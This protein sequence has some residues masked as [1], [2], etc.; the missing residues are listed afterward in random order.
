MRY[1]DSA[2]GP[3]HLVGHSYG[4]CVALRAAI[5]RPTR[6]ASMALYE[7]VAFYVLKTLGP[8]G[9]IALKEI[10][11]L[12]GEISL[13]VLSGNHQ[14]AAKRFFEFWNG[15]GSWSA[16]RPEPQEDLVRYIP[17]VCL[18]FSASINECTPLVAYRRLNFPILL[19]QG[20]HAPLP[21][22]MIARRLSKT[23]KSASLQTVHGAGHMGPFSHAQ[24]VSEL[25]AAWIMRVE[26]RFS[27][28]EGDAEPAIGRAA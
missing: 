24:V 15:A 3:V 28:D 5:E 27:T 22:Q 4:G 23:M 20:E 12:A 16:L 13:F 11:A 17:K 25:M 21:T 2:K 18:E 10:T 1:I 14:A 9:T 6:V 7:P 26:H 19:L 8:D